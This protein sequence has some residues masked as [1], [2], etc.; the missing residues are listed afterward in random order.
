MSTSH[1]V[2]DQIAARYEA[3]YETPEGQRVDRLEKAALR[4][5]IQ[6]LDVQHV[7]EIGCGTGHFSRWLKGQGLNVVG[8]DLSAAMLGQARARDGL[9]WVRGDAHR[10]PFADGSFDLSFLITTLEFL[11]Q[12]QAA[13]AE[14]MRVARRGLILG[15]LNRWSLL[16]LQRR[17]VGLWRRTT[18]DTARFYGVGG[19]KRLL[20][21]VAGN[22]PMRLI[23]RTTLFPRWGPWSE[24]CLPLPW[25]GFIAMAWLYS[26]EGEQA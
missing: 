13:L 21:S 15:V 8:L 10:L 4:W 20:R 1:T 16:G 2:F 3:W 11:A 5:L 12:P 26:P 17:L 18:Y 25:G 22:R 19:L 23:W 6:G 7:L 9:A 14:A 24:A